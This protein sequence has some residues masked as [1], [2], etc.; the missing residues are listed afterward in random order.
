MSASAVNSPL[1]HAYS[2]TG[3]NQLGGDLPYFVGKQ[4]GSGW[5]GTLARVAFPILKRIVGVASSAAEDV[6]YKD[7]PIGKTLKKHAA[8]EITNVVGSLIRG[9]KPPPPPPPPPSTINQSGR[10]RKRNSTV[11]KNTYPLFAKRK[12]KS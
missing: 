3:A 1:F 11:V 10:K 9:P 2:V 5:L 6:L 12:R 4:Y 7:K 8:K